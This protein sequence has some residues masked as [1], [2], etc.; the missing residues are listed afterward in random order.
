MEVFIY[1]FDKAM[2][3]ELITKGYKKAKYPTNS[4]YSIFLLNNEIKFDFSKFDSNK[5]KIINKLNF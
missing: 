5:Y 3:L 4:T 2:E 1:C